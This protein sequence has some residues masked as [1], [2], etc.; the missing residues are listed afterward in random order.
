MYNNYRGWGSG[1]DY[2][3]ILL[4]S[5]D[6]IFVQEHWL[7]PDHLGALS[8]S[9]DFISMG[10]SGMDACN[11]ELLVGCPYGGCGT[12]ICKSLA[13]CVRRLGKHSKRFY[14][15]AYESYK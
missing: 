13:S 14:A 1:S 10:V 15:N 8:I 7:L 9:D 4:K 11:S 12:L 5:Y 3:S 6:L 2:V